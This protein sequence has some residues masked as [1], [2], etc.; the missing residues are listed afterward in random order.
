MA[1]PTLVGPGIVLVAA[2]A[3]AVRFPMRIRSFVSAKTGRN[4]PE[5]AERYQRVFGYL[6]AVVGGIGLG[7][8]SLGL[9]SG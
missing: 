1:D 5:R 6:V 8:V 9:V 2:G 3:V 4:D 7:T